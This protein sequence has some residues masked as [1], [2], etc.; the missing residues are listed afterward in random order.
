MLIEYNL[1]L[2]NFDSKG[3]GYLEIRKGMYGLI[4][5]AILAYEQLRKH[6]ALYGYVPF[7]HTPGMWRHTTCPITF[8]LAVDNFGIK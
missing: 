6:F 7:K 5:A 4:E 1:T 3:Y 8:T 2:D